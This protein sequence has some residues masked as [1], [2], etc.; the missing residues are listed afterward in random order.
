M[1]GNHES[2][3][4]GREDRGFRD[5][6]PELAAD[7]REQRVARRPNPLPAREEDEEELAE[8]DILEELDL[9]DLDDSDM[10]DRE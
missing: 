4:E 8:A 3:D 1:P 5:D 2:F 9:D 10:F 6:E 7:D